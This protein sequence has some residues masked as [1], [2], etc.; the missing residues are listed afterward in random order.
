MEEGSLPG[1]LRDFFKY[2]YL[3]S[4][5]LEPEDAANLSIGAIMNFGKGKGLL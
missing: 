5:F 2:A 3:G 1:T 4:F